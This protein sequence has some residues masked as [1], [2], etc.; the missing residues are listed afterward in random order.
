[1][2]AIKV[3]K[4]YLPI[5][6]FEFVNKTENASRTYCRNGQSLQYSIA[7]EKQDKNSVVKIQ[8]PFFY[9]LDNMQCEDILDYKKLQTSI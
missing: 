2:L 1:M 7:I 6:C 5:Y 8:I 3:I 9:A 4:N